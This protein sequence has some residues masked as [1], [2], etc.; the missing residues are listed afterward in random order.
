MVQ[1]FLVPKWLSGI[2]GELGEEE[3]RRV[4]PYHPEIISTL[5]SFEESVFCKE[6]LVTQAANRREK[7]VTHRTE[8]HFALSVNP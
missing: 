3:D 1:S 5:P 2:T 4:W 7:G 8:T 6:P